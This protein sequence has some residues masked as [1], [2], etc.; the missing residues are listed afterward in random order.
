MHKHL[1]AYLC[2]VKTVPRLFTA[3]I[4]AFYES[5][6]QKKGVTIIKGTVACGFTQND[7]GEVCTHAANPFQN[8]VYNFF[9]FDKKH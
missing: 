3:D 7:A 4:A 8:F 1:T 9:P 5:Y 2:H 6:Y